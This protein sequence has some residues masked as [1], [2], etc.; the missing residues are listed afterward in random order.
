MSRKL[1]LAAASAGAH[2][3]PLPILEY[4]YDSAES[5]NIG[6]AVS[7]KIAVEAGVY[8]LQAD[9]DC[10]VLI[11]SDPDDR[12][13]AD[14]PSSMFYPAG[15]ER[16]EIIKPDDGLQNDNRF[17]TVIGKAGLSAGGLFRIVPVTA[18]R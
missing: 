3:T 4:D 13:S 1:W 10:Y 17:I 18:V 8:R 14:N 16:H 7:E 11:S 6:L 5:L 15:T 9:A 12:A 2:A